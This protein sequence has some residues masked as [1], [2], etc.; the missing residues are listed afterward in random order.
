MSSRGAVLERPQRVLQEVV[1]ANADVWFDVQTSDENDVQ[2]PLSLGVAIPWLHELVDNRD[3]HTIRSLYG[4]R[5][6][7]APSGESTVSFLGIESI[8]E[9]GRPRRPGFTPRR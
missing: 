9:A 1:P 2:L 3:R 6:T 4:R 8:S 7:T 5:S